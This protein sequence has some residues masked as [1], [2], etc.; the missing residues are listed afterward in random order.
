M[1]QGIGGVVGDGL[2]R[3]L[4]CFVLFA[5][6]A[7]APGEINWQLPRIDSHNRV[8]R[9]FYRSR[10]AREGGPCF[11]VLAGKLLALTEQRYSAGIV[12]KLCGY[13]LLNV[14]NRFI[15]ASLVIELYCCRKNKGLVLGIRGSFRQ[16]LCGLVESTLRLKI[17]Y[18]RCKRGLVPGRDF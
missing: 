2:S 16:N 1:R 9:R 13:L 14:S 15:K 10:R 3:L 6:A 7:I 12:R 17:Y 18:F 8:R 5:K 4:Q 11:V